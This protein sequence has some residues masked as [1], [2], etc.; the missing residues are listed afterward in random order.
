MSPEKNA[1]S[2][3]K[4]YFTQKINFLITNFIFQFTSATHSV[5]FYLL[6]AYSVAAL[7]TKNLIFVFFASISLLLSIPISLAALWSQTHKKILEK[8]NVVKIL[9]FFAFSSFTSEWEI[10]RCFFFFFSI[11]FLLRHK[12]Q[13]RQYVCT[14]ALI[15]LFSLIKSDF[16]RSLFGITIT[17][18][19]LMCVVMVLTQELLGALD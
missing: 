16:S 12:Q 4:K 6:F 17:S 1:H 11:Y 10:F 18:L 9:I 3:K 14:Y 19:I 15:S 2:C 5:I 7:Y 13:H 8:M